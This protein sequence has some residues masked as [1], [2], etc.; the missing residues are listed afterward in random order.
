MDCTA[1]IVRAVAF[2]VNLADDLTTRMAEM[3]GW[4]SRS[5]LRAIAVIRLADASPAI[6]NFDD[7]DISDRITLAVQTAASLDHVSLQLDTF[8]DIDRS[9][10]PRHGLIDRRSNLRE[11]GRR[12]SRL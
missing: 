12:L 4:A 11:A 2:Q 3:D 6:A 7:D 8:A 5:S 1:A 9:Y 10:H